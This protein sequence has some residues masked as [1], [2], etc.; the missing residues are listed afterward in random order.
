MTLGCAVAGQGRP[1]LRVFLM[2]LLLAAL[3]ASCADSEASDGVAAAASVSEARGALDS[4]DGPA[5]VAAARSQGPAA[6]VEEL[7]KDGL[8]LAGA[9]PVHLAIRG[10]PA[11]TSVRCAWR[12]VARTA[13]QREGAIRFWL[14]LGP[15]DTIP[16]VATLE[17]LFA[18]TLDTLDPKYRETAKANLLAIAR[19]GESME[20]LFLTCFVDYAVTDF[21]LGS[22]TTP[23]TVTVA[24]DRRDEAAAYELYVREHES[25]TY[26]TDALQTRGAYEAGL[27]GQVVAAE[28]ALSAEFG[29]REA[30][31]FLAPMGAHN[32]IS[33]EAWQAVAS[34]AVVTDDAG[35]VQAVRDDTPEGDPEHTQPLADLSSRIT[36]AAG[37]DDYATSRVTTVGGL[38]THYRDT[39]QAYADITP[40]D[41][42]TTTFTPRQP[43]AAP[44]CTNGT[45]VPMPADNRELVKD[46]ETLLAAKD[47]L[48]GTATLDWASGT[49]LSSWTGV[50]TGGTPTRVTGVN[51]SSQSLSGTI[52]AALG[53]LF[54]LTTLNLS[55]NS[56]TGDVP[57]EL[58]WLDHLTELRLSGN[59]LTGCIPLAL[60]A[61]ATND[62]SSLNLPYCQPPAPATLSAGTPG[63]ASVALTWAAVA[64]AGT[65]R[66]EVRQGARASWTTDSDTITGTTH[67]VDQLTCDTGYQVRVR[68]R[69]SG[70]TY[71]M[72]WSAPS[73][74]VAVTTAAC[75]PPTFTG[76]PYAFEVAERAPVGTA[77]GTLTA[78]DAEGSAVT[79][80]I[81]AGDDA[82][83]F[84]LDATS[85]ALTLAAALDYDTTASYALTVTAT[86]A[87]GGAVEAAVAI[88]V[89]EFVMDYDADDDGLIEVASLA[90]LNAIRWDLDGNG[91]AT[92][93]GHAA[94]FPDAADGMGCPISGCRGYEVTADLDFDTD[95]DGAVDADD[96]YWNGGAGWVPL[97]DATTA[98]TAT[99]QGNGHTLA[100][101]FIARPAAQQVGLVGHMGQGGSIRNLGLRA[102]AV[103][104]GDVT[105]GLVGENNRGVIRGVYVGGQVSGG[106][107]V[108][109]LVGYNLR[110]TIT[111]SYATSAVT[112]RSASVG[113]LVGFNL[114]G[115]VS[116]SYASGAVTSGRFAAGLVGFSQF[117]PVTASYAVGA[118]SASFP[119]GLVKTNRGST[120]T[121]SYWD[122]ETTGQT[123]SAGGTGQT[124]SELQT[125]TSA[126]GIY[127]T[128]GTEWDFGTASQYPALTIDF[129]RDG[130][131]SW[132]EFGDQRP[133]ADPTF[134]SATYSFS[135]AEDAAVAADV[136]TVTATAT[137]GSAVTYAITAGN[138]AGHFALDASTGALTVAV[139]LDY[140][141]TASYTLTVTATTA[142]GGTGTATVTITVTDVL[143]TAPPAPTDLAVGTV[144]TTSLPLTWTAVTGAA[145]YRV[146]YQVSG[147]ESWTTDDETLTTAAHTV[148]ALTCGTT[149]AVRVSAYGDGTAYAAAWG[150]ASAALSATTGACPAFGSATYSFSVAEDAAV[151]AAV[152]TVTAT[153]TDGSA[154]TYAITAGNDA[155]HFALDASTG[156]LTVAVAL[157][158]ETT[159]SYTLTVTA[160]TAGGGTGTATVTITVTDVLDT[161]PPA[162]TDLAVGTVTTTSLPLTWTAVTGAAKYRVEYQVSGAESWTTDD[163]TLTTA[164]HTV[165]ALTCGTTYQVRVSAYGDGT[166]HA[167][168]WGA[169]SAALSATTGACPA[170]GSA[171]YSFS[172]AEDAAVAADVGTVTAT[173]TDGSAVTYAI[174]A[175]ND[176]GHFALDASTGALTV[177][178]ALD[179][180][181]TAS[182]TLTVTATTAG[183]GTGTATVTITV[184]DVLDT[185]PPA[186]TDLAVGTVTTTS[187]PLTWTAVTGAA[188]YRVEY[189]VSGAESWTTD[190]E[191]LTTAAHTVDALTCGT[192]YAVRVSAYGD[193]TAYTAAWSKP[194]AAVPTATS[195]CPPPTFGAASYSFTVSDSAAVDAAVG[196][197]TATTT[198]SGPVTYALTA[199]N[200]GDAFAIDASTGALTVAGALDAATTAAYT[201]TVQAS[202]G[203]SQATVEVSVTVTA[204]PPAPTNLAA[205]TVTA[206][207]VP[208]TWT[209]VTSAATYRVEYQV[210]G[211]ESWTTDDDTLTT[212]A[213]TVDGLSCGTTYAVRV[214]AYGDGTTTTATWG[215]A[216]TALTVATSACAV[217]SVPVPTAAVA[218][219]SLTLRWPLVD[220]AVKYEA[221]VREAG[222][223]WPATGVEIAAAGLPTAGSHVF[224]GLTVAR[225]YEAQVRAHGNGT[226]HVADWTDWSAVVTATTDVPPAPTGLREAATTSTSV[227]VAWDALPG[228]GAYQVR[229]RQL[230]VRGWT[231]APATTS[232]SHVLDG[233]QP[234]TSYNFRVRAKGDGARYLD[235]RF[236]PSSGAITATTPAA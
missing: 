118:V 136:G 175:G 36:T 64:G 214:S 73:P 14:R 62:L 18:A 109:G 52:P 149:Y 19:G 101:L 6:T 186:P 106:S 104:G 82:G 93:A 151:D 154:V 152:G 126:S 212:A 185:A 120:I 22:G 65:Y 23:T 157:D 164:A 156:A 199:G 92:D 125:P 195:A 205:G 58:G 32:A 83:V 21:L 131:A 102:V 133:A 216:S 207:S 11:A 121:A 197:V 55:S 191:T 200:T 78:T 194:T 153:A 47:T 193:G 141:T 45:V 177:A 63:E 75:T 51:L 166:A 162:P 161:A 5:R 33:F 53:Q 213:H 188:K 98:W 159:A 222:A 25:G 46:C 202:A 26:G 178:V 122:T 187:L 145:K 117:G 31:V 86:D 220:G 77:V 173:A 181:T 225:T 85:G 169:A 108:G 95:G 130:T 54:A 210:S 218:A 103:T 68:A 217:L 110:G 17:L 4:G 171:T 28:Q 230:G 88:T 114:R 228:A 132:E 134:G 27:Q 7:L 67:T 129:D 90:Q 163:E 232:T 144:T 112:G 231:N 192:T 41:G 119:G 1:V 221:R 37:S 170:F 44:T 107:S 236:G 9:S 24:Y 8:R 99:L 66:V 234:G 128:W 190:D 180:E 208:L 165:D 20:Y 176:A 10:T 235:V 43:P 172:V 158:Y 111:T 79:Y 76:A 48:R 96:A 74:V 189:Q 150:A 167:A 100:H 97:G 94:A 203:G 84:A 196:T 40:G 182:Y 142:G 15:T 215:A 226:T 179:Y 105:G 204:A 29:G 138:D 113:G 89:T 115:T 71:A 174:T 183:G 116:A 87:S 229:Y 13:Q 146:E 139:A 209:A 155:G 30:V 233:L 143:D 206:T 80:A 81:T 227:T 2:G 57:A 184:T 50:T 211:A 69:G 3:T 70:T 147:A 34:W 91:T 124:T 160:T 224:D 59:T 168:A 135:V 49:A 140:E 201:L 61:V 35:V 198:G 38:Q 148:D 223:Q 72:A 60:Q 42:Q 137:D 56:L 39:L 123:T 219:T 12:G 127:A 16:D